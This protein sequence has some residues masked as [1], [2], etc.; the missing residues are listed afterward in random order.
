M[1]ATERLYYQDSHLTNFKAHVTALVS[2]ER[3][4]PAVTLDRTAFYPTGGGQPS[5]TG[6]LGAARV[7]ECINDEASGVLH[8]VEG[9]ALRVGEEVVGSIDWPRRLDHIQQHTGQHILSQAFIEL[10][11]AETRGFRM[12]ERVSE[13]DVALND[14]TDER[15]E[16][17]VDLANRIIWEDRAIRIHHVTAEQ[18]A[19]MPLRKE[20][21]R[22]G[23]TRVI[24]IEGFDMNACGG[25]HAHRTGE[26]GVIAVPRWERAKGL[27]RVEFVAGGRALNDYRQANRTAREVA[28]LFSVGRDDSPAS[29]SRLMEE[30]KNLLRRMRV[31]E[32]I[33]ARVEAEELINTSVQKQSDGSRIV[34]HIFDGRDAESLKRLA[35][36]V[37]SHPQSIALLGSRDGDDARLVFARSPDATGDMGALMREACATLN[38]RGGGRPDLAQ[39]GG[40]NTESLRIAIEAAARRL[41]EGE[42]A[43]APA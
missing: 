8:V 1:N 17:A 29:V 11:G 9:D 18:A 21:K 33:A 16:R 22:E 30:N 15:T 14:P 23:H 43:C 26:V 25:T 24:E 40:R 36:A 37:A 31:L 27:T 42:R 5:D 32:E 7:V 39:G 38:G 28:A 2:D 3:G 6:T 10:F 13:I 19:A 34:T 12:M 41:S 35:L 20:Q 4:R